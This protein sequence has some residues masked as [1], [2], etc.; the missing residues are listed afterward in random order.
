MPTDTAE[1]K[2]V[3]P[4]AV[5]RILPDPYLQPSLEC[6]PL[7]LAGNTLSLL[8]SG[9][10]GRTEDKDKPRTW[11]GHREVRFRKGLGEEEAE[12]SDVCMLSRVQLCDPMDC[13]PPGSS[14]YGTFQV[15]ILEWVATFF[16][17]ES[18]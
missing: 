18:P 16:S 17:R 1:A 9:F 4:P 5:C 11:V 12:G 14:V 2:A 13:S 7:L 3:V 6:K 10:G 15:I 8:K